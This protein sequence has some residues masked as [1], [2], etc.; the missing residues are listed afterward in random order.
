MSEIQIDTAKVLNSAT[1]IQQVATSLRAAGNRIASAG[2][3]APVFEKNSF[4]PN[5]RDLCKACK[6][7]LDKL[8]SVLENQATKLRERVGK[9]EKADQGQTTIITS[10]F[11]IFLD[12]FD[13]GKDSETDSPAIN[14]E[15]FDGKHEAVEEEKSPFGEMLEEIETEKKLESPKLNPDAKPGNYGS[16]A[17]YAAARRPDLG[18]TKSSNQKFRDQAAANYIYK[19]KDKVFQVDSSD[20]DLTDNLAKG[21]A[22]VWEPGVQ[23]SHKDDG[24]VAIIEEIGKDYVIVSQAGW[25]GKDKIPISKL[26][27]LWIIP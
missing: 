26:K 10:I 13:R 2:A 15:E 24:H 3:S 14:A 25:G 21:Y 4:G 6:S 5:V 17:L 19:F 11:G 1:N 23:G 18:T 16:C 12:G 9:F 8:A 27:D 20:T 22:V 7:A